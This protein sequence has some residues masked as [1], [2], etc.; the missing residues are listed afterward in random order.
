MSS[1]QQ[2]PEALA[3]AAG[4]AFVNGPV[5]LFIVGSGAMAIAV[6]PGLREVTDEGFHPLFAFGVAMLAGATAGWLWWSWSLPR[7]KA[8]AYERVEDLPK[9]KVYAFRT[10]L[11]WP[12]GHPL[13]RT[14]Y[15]PA[16]LRSR[17]Q[18]AEAVNQRRQ[19]R[20]GDA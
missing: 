18:R 1:R 15:V 12:S 16:K 9:L 13:E 7:W 5:L 14:E 19:T 3:T 11:C 2:I 8:W 20:H 10:G 6:T 4:L 17:I